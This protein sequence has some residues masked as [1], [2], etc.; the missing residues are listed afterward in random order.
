MKMSNLLVLLAVLCLFGAC[1][2]SGNYEPINNKD[3]STADTVAADSTVSKL[4]KTAEMN[5]KVKN[6]SAVSE[7]IVNLT[8]RYHGMVMH[9]QMQSDELRSQ[10]MPLSSDSLMRVSVIRTTAGITV[11]IPSDSLEQY[12]NRV[13]KM[14]LHVNLRRMDIEDKTLDYLSAQLK[15]NS[16]NQ[17]ISQQ[18]TGRIK[19]KDPADVLWLKDSMID[20]KIN[21][22]K[23]DDA[24]KNS[25]VDMSLYQSDTIIK[26]NIANDDPTAYQ[27]PF[28]KR[29][30][31]A[32]VNGWNLFAAFFIGIANLWLFILAGFGTWL[33]LKLYKRKAIPAINSI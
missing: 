22:K 26:E 20:E 27:L 8:T 29:L 5:I 3:L 18:K 25:V 11:K 1:K 28:F 7:G 17:L 10:D 6:V 21:N 30:L 15:L 14:G 33:L 23:I 32:L 2:G 9:H 31:L 16:R 4:V 19:I 13:E 24:A 12:M